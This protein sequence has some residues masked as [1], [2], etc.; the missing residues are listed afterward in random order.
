MA[1]L[2]SPLPLQ[3]QRLGFP[4]EYNSYA[5]PGM[6]DMPSAV[7]P[8]DGSFAIVASS[9]AGQERAGLAFQFLPRLSATFLYSHPN[10]IQPDP[11]LPVNKKRYDRSFYLHYQIL[12]EG[13]LLPS[14]AI[15]INDLVGTGLYSSEFLVSPQVSV[16]KSFWTTLLP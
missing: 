15:G 8:A 6:L 7:R 11:N 12:D 16:K 10:N 14:V 5:V 1:G 13:K 9:F 4:A 2:C 3:A